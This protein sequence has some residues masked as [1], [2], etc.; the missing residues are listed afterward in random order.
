MTDNSGETPAADSGETSADVAGD[1]PADVPAGNDPFEVEER[2]AVGSTFH[3]VDLS[4]SSFHEVRL[5]EAKINDADLRGFVVRDAYVDGLVL[6][7]VMGERL[8][9][10]G[11]FGEVIVNGVDVAPF[12]ESELAR[13]HPEYALM[14]PD[15]PAGF[16][17]AWD[18]VESFWATTISDVRSLGESLLHESV[19]GEWS[20]IQ[21]LRHLVFATECWVH[22][23]T[24]GE[25]APWLPL[26]L[27]WDSM[28]PTEGVPWDRDARPTLAEVLEMRADRMGAVRRVVEGLTEEQ[29]ASTGPELTGPGWPPAGESFPVRESL[30]TVLNEEWCHHRFALRDLAVL[31]AR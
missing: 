19:A 28:P 22:R 4:G 23:A 21:T 3:L 10:D 27:P 13:R 6:T 18:A 17:T 16:V 7:G 26:S 11:E 31:T 2:H 20:F 8:Q 25:M 14:K 24:L 29:L 15:D 1:K 12:V 9:L 5:R 30:H